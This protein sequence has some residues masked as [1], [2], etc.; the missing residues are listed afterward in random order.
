MRKREVAELARRLG[1][2]FETSNP[3]DGKR[4]YHFQWGTKGQFAR[5]TYGSRESWTF[6]VGFEAGCQH[7]QEV[8]P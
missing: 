3:G 6:L 1:M 7:M 8:K 5:T 2:T 4:R